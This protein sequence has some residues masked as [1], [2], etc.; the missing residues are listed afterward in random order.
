MNRRPKVPYIC[1]KKPPQ[2]NS[3]ILKHNKNINDLP[4]ELLSK[5]LQYLSGSDVLRCSRIC[6]HWLEACCQNELWRIQFRRLPSIVQKI[7]IEAK[8]PNRFTKWKAEAILCLKKFRKRNTDVLLKRKNRYS[9]LPEKLP[10]VLKYLDLQWTIVVLDATGTKYEFVTKVAYQHTTSISVCWENVEL[11][12]VGRLISCSIFVQSPLFRDA[13]GNAVEHSVCSRSLLAKLSLKEHA[14]ANTNLLGSDQYVSIIALSEGLAF[15]LWHDDL[16]PQ[17]NVAFI[18]LNL[19]SLN[20]VERILGGTSESSYNMPVHQPILDDIDRKYG[21]QKY[22]ALIELRTSKR[23]LWNHKVTEFF[24]G[25]IEDG[26][27][28]FTDERPAYQSCFD[29]RH[30]VRLPWKAG[31]IRGTIKSLAIV[32]LSLIDCNEDFMWHTS[33]IVKATAVETNEVAFEDTGGENLMLVLNDENKGW[34]KLIIA[35]DPDSDRCAVRRIDIGL[36]I[37]FINSWFQTSY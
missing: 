15:G 28:L 6:K 8:K 9:G 27:L 7:S 30:P 25:Q 34:L 4:L 20:I 16:L 12:S 32:D 37:N 18:T 36:K 5:I 35:M 3:A 31:A 1:L 14:F 24:K 29:I 33:E 22:S 11:P 10:E 26:Y 19:H 13:K 23:Q 2:K 17:R 21:L